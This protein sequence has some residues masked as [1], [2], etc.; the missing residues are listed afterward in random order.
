MSLWIHYASKKTNENRSCASERFA[1]GTQLLPLRPKTK[2]MEKP[3]KFCYRMKPSK[4]T[5]VNSSK[6]KRRP[7]LSIMLAST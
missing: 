5:S 4:I 1:P 3:S 7:R 6:S 2:A